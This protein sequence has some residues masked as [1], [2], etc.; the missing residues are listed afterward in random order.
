[1]AR[2]WAFGVPNVRKPCM[3]EVYESN[4]STRHLLC[5]LG[6]RDLRL[7]VFQQECTIK[8]ALP[9]QHECIAQRGI[10]PFA[11][12][13]KRGFFR[14]WIGVSLCWIIGL[15]WY[16]RNDLHFEGPWTLSSPPLDCL[17]DPTRP[18]C[19]TAATEAQSWVERSHAAVIIFVPPLGLFIFGSCVVWIIQ[20]FIPKS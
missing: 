13:I 20:G 5:D 12:N 16:L 3:E 11:M 14:L 9:L 15:S 4:P 17:R 19:A 18:Q 2:F 6:N 1:M 7:R 10:G 8:R